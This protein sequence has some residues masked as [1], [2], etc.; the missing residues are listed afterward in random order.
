MG[1]DI[2]IL[3]LDL[4]PGATTI[5]ELI[6]DPQ[7]IGERAVVLDALAEHFPGHTEGAGGWSCDDHLGEIHLADGDPVDFIG[8]TPRGDAP[9]AIAPVF[10]F[11]ER[12]GAV[13]FAYSDC[14]ILT[15]QTALEDWEAFRGYR[16]HVYG[17]RPPPDG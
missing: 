14:A 16:A 6:G 5:N 2:G 10:A 7:P 9:R 13:V 4:P 12:F 3:K 1:W 17:R 11:A 8:I 15:P